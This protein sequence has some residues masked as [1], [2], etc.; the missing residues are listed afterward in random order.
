MVNEEESKFINEFKNYREYFHF[1]VELMEDINAYND[2]RLKN[3]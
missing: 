1:A 2:E 3:K